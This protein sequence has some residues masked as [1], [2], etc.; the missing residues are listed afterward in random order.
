MYSCLITIL[1]FLNFN[2]EE[3]SVV[4]IYIYWPT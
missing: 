1:V 3:S 4:V 2:W